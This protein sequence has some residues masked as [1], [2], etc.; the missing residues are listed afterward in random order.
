MLLRL[1]APLLSPPLPPLEAGTK[2]YLSTAHAQALIDAGMA[3]E[4]FD[5][6][7][8][9]TVM[10]QL[11]DTLPLGAQVAFYPLKIAV[12]TAINEGRFPLVQGLI[13][14]AEAP[15]EYEPIRQGMLALL[16]QLAG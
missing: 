3:E 12:N 16:A 8:L 6:E 14:T 2:L 13:E 5:P 1:L 9:K 10:T 7:T 4:A 11:W 15:A